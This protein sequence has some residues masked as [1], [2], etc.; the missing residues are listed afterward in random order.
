MHGAVFSPAYFDDTA[1][2]ARHLPV[3][4]GGSFLEIGCGT[5]ALLLAACMRLEPIGDDARAVRIRNAFEST[6]KGGK[7]LTR[8]LGG[9]ASTE[10]FTDAV[11]AA[12]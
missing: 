8:D 10:E 12:L 2:F 3:G 1:F 7:T 6:L 4:R 11:I 9:Q 5:G